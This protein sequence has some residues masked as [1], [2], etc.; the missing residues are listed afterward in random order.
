MNS[1]ALDWSGMLD[2]LLAAESLG[3]DEACSVLGSI[4]KDEVDP[5]MIAALLIAL[6]AKGESA[7]ELAGFVRAMTGAAAPI[8]IDAAIAARLVDVVGTGGDGADTFN[9]STIAAVVVAAA[10]QPVAKHGNRSASSLCG[11][12]DLIEGWGIDLELP[13]AAIT[14]CIEEL[15]IGFLFARSFHP[16]MKVVGPIRAQLGIRTTFNLLG[17]LSNPASAPFQAVGVA[18]P[19]RAPVM[20][21]ALAR[22]GRRALVFSGGDG[23]DEL[24]TTTSSQAWEVAD[25]QVQETLIDPSEVGIAR[26]TPKDL[27]G[28]DVARNV[29]IADAILAGEPGPRA[30]V[31]VLNAAAALYVAGAVEDLSAGVELAREVLNQGAA[32]DLKQRWVALARRLA[33]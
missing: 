21:A 15:G 8:D 31:V 6:R 22:L 23:L 28:G 29:E 2:R 17:P 11:S 1:T 5:V 18:D 20:A 7:A 10:G 4:M 33:G 30:D 32:L 13:A 14:T 25:G 12:A 19:L 26:A 24:T 3:E 27:S 16:A 9:I